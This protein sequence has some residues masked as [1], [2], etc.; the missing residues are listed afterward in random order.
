MRAL[1]PDFLA[2]LYDIPL[3]E[4]DWEPVLR[5]L[6]NRAHTERAALIRAGG[7]GSGPEVVQLLGVDDAILQRY[8]DH[9]AAIDPFMTAIGRE[10]RYV[11]RAFADTEILP[12][13]LLERTE[14][15]NEFWR[16]SRIGHCLS[17]C[18]VAGAGAP[19]HII[20]PRE[21]AQGPPTSDEIRQLQIQLPH[22]AR[23]LR[24][25]NTLAGHRTEPDL[26]AF[27]RAHL[28]T[29][30]ETKLLASLC[31]SGDLRAAGNALS[32]SYHTVRAQLRS[33]F[34]KTGVH[35]QMQLAALLHG[36]ADRH[37]RS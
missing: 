35:S 20:L 3:G 33:V 11:N 21:P 4:G 16:P 37:D 13:K 28:L 15:F 2:R 6:A 32:R 10:A 7:S 27:A 1:D 34:F 26:E 8:A 24:L 31:T 29:D 14:F 17:A 19:V 18:C 30:A 12:R 23:A 22:I 5:R 25:V 36:H 9:Y